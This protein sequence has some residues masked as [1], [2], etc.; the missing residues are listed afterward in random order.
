MHAPFGVC[1]QCIP[2]LHSKLC[3]GLLLANTADCLPQHAM[4]QQLPA[5]QCSAVQR[6]V[7]P[8]KQLQAL[9]V[10]EARRAAAD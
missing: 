6:A 3:S 1:S 10:A 8:S 7:L 2:A 5:V 4:L 9:H